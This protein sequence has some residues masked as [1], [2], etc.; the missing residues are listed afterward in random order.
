MNE[1]RVALNCF[2]QLSGHAARS[3]GLDGM[4]KDV[5]KGWQEQGQGS[6][7]TKPIDIPK[8]EYEYAKSGNIPAKF[9]EL[10][11]EDITKWPPTRSKPGVTD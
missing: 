11:K 2:I 7:W 10:G 4:V 9:K 6:A 5:G 1:L 3:A 8:A